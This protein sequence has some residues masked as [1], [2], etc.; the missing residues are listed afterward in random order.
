MTC[1]ANLAGARPIMAA[2][3]AAMMSFWAGTAGADPWTVSVSA[4]LDP[5][6]GLASEPYRV[7]SGF[8]LPGFPNAD[9]SGVAIEVQGA[10]EFAFHFTRRFDEL[11]WTWT[12]RVRASFV[13][14]EA[15]VILPDGVSIL[16]DPVR[17]TSDS[18]GVNLRASL[19]APTVFDRIV[20][21]GG[22]GAVYL[23]V[24]DRFDYGF[25]QAEEN[26][27]VTLPYAFGLVETPVLS[28]A[29]VSLHAY[30]EVHYSRLGTS[31]GIGL[32]HRF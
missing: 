12:P 8:G 17:A 4:G 24:T 27:E 10:T 23:K 22:A 11:D 30:G 32:E 25:L 21:E 15:A 13:T 16:V 28:A 2:F 18:R 6:V 14:R 20:L 29:G 31:W 1:I 5:H 7:N 3:C 19:I 26:R 9:T